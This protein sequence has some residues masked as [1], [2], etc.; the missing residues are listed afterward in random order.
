MDAG[1]QRRESSGLLGGP[2]PTRDCGEHPSPVARRQHLEACTEALDC[3]DC[4]LGALAGNGLKNARQ[5]LGDPLLR[6]VSRTV[7]QRPE[8]CRVFH[9]GLQPIGG[10][11]RCS[12]VQDVGSD[13][14]HGQIG[15]DG[16]GGRAGEIYAAGRRSHRVGRTVGDNPP[17][18]SAS[19]AVGAR[20]SEDAEMVSPRVGIRGLRIDEL[21]S[22]EQPGEMTPLAV[23]TPHP[24][25]S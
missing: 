5:L 1:G 24:G 17:R 18:R 16:A 7:R 19:G 6:V 20:A 8:P 15:V 23:G 22:G 13:S 14:E 12:L 3:P 4:A 25:L 2:G 9:S 10:R 21:L 11:C